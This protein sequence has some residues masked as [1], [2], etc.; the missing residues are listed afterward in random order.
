MLKFVLSFYKST[1]RKLVPLL[2][3]E[4]QPFRI[5]INHDILVI[6]KKHLGMCVP[7]V[8]ALIFYNTKFAH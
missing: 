4:T 7:S 8:E 6:K 5:K 2:D 3:F 1:Q